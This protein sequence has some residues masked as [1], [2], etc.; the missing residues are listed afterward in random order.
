M[1]AG[2]RGFTSGAANLCPRLS[3]GIFRALE[4]SDFVEAM[5]L[6]DVLRPIEDF[7]AR[8]G[9]S[10]NISLLKTAIRLTGRDFGPVRPPQRLLTA[11]EEA[12]VQTM[13]E[14]ILAAEAATA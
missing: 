4:R 6:L 13:L 11:V 2:A 9:D 14:P 8:A 10:Y 3:L 7:R 5:R 12:D 1:L